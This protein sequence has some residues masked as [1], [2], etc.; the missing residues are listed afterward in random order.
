M[1]WLD[2]LEH[3]LEKRYV[4]NGLTVPF[5]IGSKS[6]L[7]PDEPLQ[8]VKE[9]LTE[10]SENEPPISLMWCGKVRH[11]ILS[12]MD[13][14]DIDMRVIYKNFG[15]LVIIDN[16]FRDAKSLEDIISELDTELSDEI[17]GGGFSRLAG[18]WHPYD[19]D[20]ELPHI[21]ELLEEK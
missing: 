21:K 4:D 8:S 13:S 12:T 6:V 14:Y 19:A 3:F 20:T 17:K 1:D 10:I 16:S 18:G 7:E 15:N 5:L 2:V 9:F 11:Y